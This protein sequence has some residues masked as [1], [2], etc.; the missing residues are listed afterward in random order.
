MPSMHLSAFIRPKDTV[1]ATG[2]TLENGGGCVT[3]RVVGDGESSEIAVFADDLARLLEF[4]QAIVREV[5]AVMPREPSNKPGDPV[6]YSLVQDPTS[7][8]PEGF[9]PGSRRPRSLGEEYGDP[10]IDKFLDDHPF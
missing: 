2:V 6:A 4:G 5:E 7:Y 10:A 8:E 9:V 1:H 3:V